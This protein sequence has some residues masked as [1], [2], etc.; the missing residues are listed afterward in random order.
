[1]GK[2]LIMKVL[3]HENTNGVIPWV[4]FAGVHAGKLKGFTG[5]EILTDSKKLI[6][7]LLEVHKLYEPDGMPIVFDL[8]LEAEILGCELLWADYNPPSVTSH[9]FDKEK[10]IPCK[11]LFPTSESGR[12]P[13]VLDA[14]RVLKKEIGDDTALFGLICGPLTL[15]SHL[16]GSDFFKDMRKDPDYVEQL[17][18]YCA[19]YAQ[20]MADLYIEAGMD[21]IAVVDPLVSQI[22]PK[23]FA[24]LLH[25]PFKAVFDYIRMKG[26]KSSFF[27]CGN[28][29]YQIDVM[30]QTGPDAIA[31][32]ENVDMVAAKAVTDQYNI[33][34]SGNIPLT[35]T[36]LFGNQQDNIKGVLDLMDSIENKHNLMISPGCDMPYDVPLENTVACAMAVHRPDDA[37]VMVANYTASDFDDIDIEIPNYKSRDKVYIELFTLDP[38]QC[39]ACTYMV[40]SVTDIFDE[41][42][43]MAD[44]IVYKYFIKEDIAR[45]AKMGLKNLPTMCFDGESV[46]ISIIPDRDQL[47]DEV[48]KRYN[49]K[50]NI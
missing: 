31:V 22:S 46:Y 21:V 19:E 18:A 42:S 36:M 16:R 6:D 24:K 8:Q 44:Y 47:I 38:E 32:D 10:G 14:M 40:K 12:I 2:E 41:I 5:K 13:V 28:A 34:L 3:N 39:A 27:V 50:H 17:A 49:A 9:L 35:T 37:R 29:S 11:C 43:D 1:M 15:G 4:P 33:A 30:C 23:V 25:E 20:K 7:S 48:R 26:V 45:T